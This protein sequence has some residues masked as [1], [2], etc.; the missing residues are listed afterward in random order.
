MVRQQTAAD[1]MNCLVIV[2]AYLVAA[3]VAGRRLPSVFYGQS[4]SSILFLYGPVVAGWALSLVFTV[5]I[6]KRG[7]GKSA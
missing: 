7:S 6:R 4:R 2:S 1:A 5:Y 3:Y